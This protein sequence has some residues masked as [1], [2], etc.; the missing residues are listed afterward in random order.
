MTEKKFTLG[1]KWIA[2]GTI[3]EIL[4]DEKVIICCFDNTLCD[5]NPIDLVD[6]LNTQHEEIEQL[7]QVINDYGS[8]DVSSCMNTIFRLAKEN[9]QL[10]QS[11][12]RLLKMLDNV[13]NYMQKENKYML[14][15]DF[16]EWWNNIATKRLDG[17]VE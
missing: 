12:K 9:E 11:N 5:E 10:K 4:D 6:L 3:V 2:E 7:K 16:V 14:V 1:K 8:S 15:D 13:A 17:D